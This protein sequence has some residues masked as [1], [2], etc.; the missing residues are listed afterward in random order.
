MRTIIERDPYLPEKRVL[1]WTKLGRW[2]CAWI[3]CSGAGEPPFVTAY[4]RR[5]SLEQAAQ[6][7]L[8]TSA[9]ERYELYLDGELIGRGPERGDAEN[10]FYETY[11][12]APGLGEHVL[13]A[14]VWSLGKMAPFAQMS[15]QPGFLLSPQAEYVEL[16]G[17]GV[18]GWEAKRLEGIQFLDPAPAW[19]T[20]ANLLVDGSQFS[21]GFELG[22]GENWQPAITLKPATSLLSDYEYQPLRC[23]RPATLPAMFGQEVKAGKIRFV[24]AA[25]SLDTAL[26]PIVAHD[27]L[28]EE[29]GWDRLIHSDLSVTIPPYTTRRV[30]IDLENY[31]CAYPEIITSG[32]VGSR[33]RL[34]WAEA[35]FEKPEAQ[36]SKGNRDEI[37][38]KY[39]IGVGDTF[40]PDGGNQRHFN[41]LWW[42]AG[43]YLELM[44]ETGR[45]SLTIER[46]ILRETHYPV[47][48]ESTFS[49][50][51]QPLTNI[52]PIMVRSIQMDAHETYMDCPYYEQLQYVGDTRLEILAT[53]VMTQDDR[54]PRKALQMFA[55]SRQ[56][57]GLTQSR[58]P[59]RV[60][61][62]IPPFSLWWV[63]ML[64][65]YALWRGDRSFVE[66]LM[67][68]ARGIVERFRLFI[69]MDG[70]LRVPYGWNFMDWVPGWDGGIPPEG[71]LG[72]SGMINWQFVLVQQMLAEL[73][74]MLGNFQ[75]AEA[76]RLQAK[77][78]AER[79]SLSFWDERRGLFADDLAKAHFTEHTQCLAILSGLLGQEH[80]KKVTSSLLQEGGMEKTTVYFTYYLFEA[81]QKTGSIE[82][83][84]RRMQMWL[85]MPK[86]GL[87]TTFEMPEPSRS[88]C[89]AWGAH[90]LYHYFA[91][92]LGIRPAGLGFKKV[93]I[94]PLLGP[95]QQASGKLVHPDGVIEV[96]FYNQDRFLHGKISLP[97]GVSGTL[98]CNGRSLPLKEGSQVF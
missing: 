40:L 92:I 77:L 37:E 43:R 97:G 11:D 33:V 98:F 42:Q 90:P 84:F 35:L 9:D 27:H 61:Q 38:N 85:D 2:P 20:G 52:I 86:I 29:A 67:P 79:V 48:M 58:Y 89:H 73:E 81:Y 7:R 60:L 82:A 56:P 69:S 76:V 75:Q 8:H 83:F 3:A 1:P 57:D 72:A 21:W 53:Y 80:L 62:I 41:T 34:L 74:D 5:F 87:K 22:K 30:I 63:G 32:G 59:S 71:S 91:T 93:T 23:M 64:R 28:P 6:I 4:R 26:I 78:L 25:V 17:T 19:G 94:T 65:D 36:A 13:V 12:L 44:V 10:W 16:L 95:L 88:D 18:A 39:F 49:A 51:G 14:R 50:I 46:L 66:Q 15:V 55:A 96:D 54:L 45:D 24:S 31:Y 47:E 68:V 70:L